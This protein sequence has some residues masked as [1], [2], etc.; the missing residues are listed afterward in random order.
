MVRCNECDDG[1][2]RKPE[3]DWFQPGLFENL[4]Q[5]KLETFDSKIFFIGSKWMA[6]FLGDSF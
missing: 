3:R 6:R 5:A 4:Y 1:N 2:E